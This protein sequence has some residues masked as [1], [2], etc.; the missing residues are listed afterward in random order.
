MGKSHSQPWLIFLGG[1][2]YG[3][4]GHVICKLLYFYFVLL[5]LLL[6]YKKAF[7]AFFQIQCNFFLFFMTFNVSHF[8]KSKFA[9]QEMCTYIGKLLLLKQEYFEEDNAN[10]A[11]W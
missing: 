3:K 7:N 5:F 1:N 2:I 8:R 4:Y 11:S 9:L 10:F 6:S